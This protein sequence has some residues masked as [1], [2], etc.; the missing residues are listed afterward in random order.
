M[1]M[2]LNTRSAGLEMLR[3]VRIT[4][5]DTV[6][7]G[8]REHRGVRDYLV[9]WLQNEIYR[10][11][12]C[13]MTPVSAPASVPLLV[14]ALATANAGLGTAQ[15]G[16]YMASGRPEPA[17]TKWLR[18]YWHVNPAGALLL[19]RLATGI[20]NR[21][22]VPFRLKVLLDTSIARRDAAVL[23]LPLGQWMAGRDIV[24]P[25]SRELDEMDALGAA[26]PLFTKT[27][28]PG[29]GLAED[30]RTGLSFGMHR[31]A[32]VARSLARSYVAGHAEEE[33]QW[34]GLS[35]EFAREGLSLDRPYLN[36]ASRDVYEF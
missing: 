10:N 26:T 1:A 4:S 35:A 28:R 7:I 27:L 8:G 36:A 15:P 31:S 3:N 16:W 12:F 32:L 24:G 25:V 34:S 13:R 14:R 21:L 9:P 5:P 11:F 29:V 18:L 2:D 22:L 33:Q 23:Y 6:H 17:G 20:L 19:T 30:P